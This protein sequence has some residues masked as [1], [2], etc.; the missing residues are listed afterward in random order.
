[1]KALYSSDLLD[2]DFKLSADLD[3][4]LT[5]EA[6]LVWRDITKHIYGTVPIYPGISFCVYTALFV[7]LLSINICSMMRADGCDK[8]SERGSGSFNYETSI[9]QQRG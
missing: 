6:V 8:Y 5:F 4:K 3:I 2:F 9:T 1:M 7:L